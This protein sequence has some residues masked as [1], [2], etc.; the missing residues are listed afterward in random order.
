MALTDGWGPHGKP[1]QRFPWGEGGRPLTDDRGL[2]SESPA[3]S[4]VFRRGTPETIRT[5]DL[6]LR[7]LKIQLLEFTV[8]SRDVPKCL[9][10]EGLRI[11]ELPEGSPCT[12]KSITFRTCRISKSL[13]K[14]EANSVSSLGA[15]IL[16]CF[17]H[18]HPYPYHHMHP[19]SGIAT[20][21]SVTGL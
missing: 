5:S 19:V 2:T 17:C 9:R 15:V 7:S 18:C 8:V 14:T 20:S 16:L 13:A 21:C 11:F 6:P 3:S 12:L 1:A 10:H 4:G